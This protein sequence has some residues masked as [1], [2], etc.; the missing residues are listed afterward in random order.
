MKK[1]SNVASVYDFGAA[2]EDGREEWGVHGLRLAR[3][4]SRCC[5]SMLANPE[6]RLLHIMGDAKIRRLVGKNA[7]RV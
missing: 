3:N 1:E 4:G 7:R 5:C 2:K 6:G